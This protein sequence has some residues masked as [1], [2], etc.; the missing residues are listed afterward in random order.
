MGL[1]VIVIAMLIYIAIGVQYRKLEAKVLK[2][3]GYVNWNI[4]SYIDNRYTETNQAP[5]VG[6]RWYVILP[7]R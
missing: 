4:V 1:V 5:S 7:T 3:L 6:C 2:K